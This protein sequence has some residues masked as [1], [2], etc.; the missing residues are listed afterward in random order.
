MQAQPYLEPRRDRS[1]YTVHGRL[2][3]SHVYGTRAY[4]RHEKTLARILHVSA[5]ER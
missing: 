4:G 3:V 1:S 5:T 2:G